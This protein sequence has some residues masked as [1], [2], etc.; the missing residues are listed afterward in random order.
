M[1]LS[2]SALLV[3]VA[4]IDLRTRRISNYWNLMN[5]LALGAF[6]TLWGEFYSW[7]WRL[8]LLPL[9]F[10]VVGFLLFLAGI[11]G[12]G[13]S[14]FLATFSLALPLSLHADFLEALITVTVLVGA[15]LLTL[16]L[17]TQFGQVKAYLIGLHWQGLRELFRTQNSF[18]P[19]ILLGWLLLGYRY[20]A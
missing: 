4:L 20:F 19:V 16:R 15:L 6:S 9:G 17:V 12:A 8:L 10:V 18:A 2:L 5:L 3:V 13:D 1:F 7:D 11:M 14:K